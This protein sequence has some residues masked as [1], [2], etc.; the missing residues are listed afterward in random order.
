M[1]QMVSLYYALPSEKENDCQKFNMS[2]Q[3]IPGNMSLMDVISK[4]VFQNITLK[5]TLFM[6]FKVKKVKKN[7]IKKRRK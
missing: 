2:V 5:K 1:S 3:L 6:L 7:K 4:T